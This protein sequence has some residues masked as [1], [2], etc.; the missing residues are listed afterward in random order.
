MRYGIAKYGS[1][2][3]GSGPTID[4]LLWG[5][6]VDWDGDGYFTGENE[7]SHV[8]SFRSIR[9]RNNIVNSGLTGLETMKIGEATL[10]LDNSDGRYDP[11]N[12]ASP[13]YNKFYPGRKAKIIVKKGTSG[14]QYDVFYGTVSDLR[15]YGYNQTADMVIN[16]L[17]QSLADIEGYH[18]AVKNIKASNAISELLEQSGF[19]I[20][21]SFEDTLTYM[22]YW[23]EANDKL[24]NQIEKLAES[25]LS[26]VFIDSSGTLKL[27]NR[28]HTETP[29][30]ITQSDLLK[31]I[32]RS[33]P[34]E[35]QIGKLQIY[36]SSFDAQA[37]QVIWSLDKPIIIAAGESIKLICQYMQPSYHVLTPINGID[38]ILTDANGNPISFD[39][40]DF[41]DRGTT[42]ILELVNNSG[43]DG[44]V[45]LARIYGEPL[46]EANKIG[47][48]NDISNEIP[49]VLIFDNFRLQNTVAAQEYAGILSDYFQ[50]KPH[51]CTIVIEGRPDLQFGVELMKQVHLI[52]N[53]IGIDDTYQIIRIEHEW[54]SANGSLIRTTIKLEPPRPVGS[55]L[56][57][58]Y[59]VPAGGEVFWY[60]NAYDIPAD[61]ELDTSFSE[62]YVRAAS[63]PS[64]TIAGNEKHLHTV[65]NST[66]VAG[67]AHPFTSSNTG[68]AT[69][70]AIKLK[71]A[72]SP[73]HSNHF[74]T[75]THPHGISSGNTSTSASHSHPIG[76]TGYV[77][78]LPSYMA[79]YLIRAKVDTVCP[80]NGVV[81]TSKAPSYFPSGFVV[82]NGQNG[83]PDIRD[84]FV[85]GAKD[86]DMVGV[87]GGYK[88][89]KHVN[90]SV[91]AGGG[92]G[93]T[94]TGTTNV[95]TSSYYLNDITAG[96]GINAPGEE[97]VH[98][99][100]F[101]TTDE[102][103]HIHTLGDTE[104]ADSLPSYVKL[105]YIMRLV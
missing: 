9:G 68:N 61:Y 25:A 32:R 94:K 48:E 19:D 80:I 2:K 93:H 79:L 12:P 92:H 74:V 84:R 95:V 10:T 101:T 86:D 67:H 15:V 26:S 81:M 72:G 66:S 42:A 44:I 88:D 37:S 65:P 27:F 23:W 36:V 7:A 83:T 24:K 78:N 13:L 21:T 34:W 105:Y 29:L 97:H 64:D 17:W 45:T 39:I 62:C 71:S 51:I 28:M 43:V 59:I 3:Y 76:D 98:D 77:D 58:D 30:N 14:T 47:I 5:V 41:E 50:N 96:T 87:S 70:T 69:G 11:Y 1:F 73:Y 102:P 90:G 103:D 52:A 22:P 35:E 75:P 56:D 57:Y 89:H 31:D 38:V 85:Y 18:S 99:Y 100:S 20:S 54:I 63:A 104:L 4:N 91:G 6:I 33:L 53:R 82:C 55:G 60:G 46:N 49:K 8:I 16:D 40:T